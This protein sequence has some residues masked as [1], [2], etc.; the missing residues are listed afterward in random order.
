[1]SSKEY[2]IF[3][4]SSKKVI[5]NAEYFD[6]K[7]HTSIVQITPEM[8]KKQE[9]NI[10]YTTYINNTI[11]NNKNGYN[12]GVFIKFKPMKLIRCPIFRFNKDIMGKYNIKDDKDPRRFHFLIS[13]DPEDEGCIQ[14][15][16]VMSGLDKYYNSADFGKYM[17]AENTKIMKDDDIKFKPYGL[18]TSI[19]QNQKKKT[20]DKN[21]FKDYASVKIKLDVDQTG[22]IKTMFAKKNGNNIIKFTV[23]NF[24]DLFEYIGRNAVIQPIIRLKKVYSTKGDTDGDTTEYRC[25]ITPVFEQVI[26]LDSGSTSSSEEHE[27]INDD[28]YNVI[29]ASDSSTV[30]NPTIPK[31]IM[32]KSEPKNITD[33]PHDEDDGELEDSEE[34]TDNSDTIENEEQEDESEEEPEEEPEP[35]PEPKPT[36]RIIK[37]KSSDK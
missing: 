30:I 6:P 20:A 25:G 26:I 7:K 33:E 22:T 18:Y 34:I 19:K 37:K 16:K 13:I 5:L 29:E 4:T 31:D 8:E 17:F 10:Q 1:M 24:D 21:P 36:K 32:N 35:E 27:F 2:T 14:L 28:G 3:G 15:E 11:S 23:N 9:S 12:K